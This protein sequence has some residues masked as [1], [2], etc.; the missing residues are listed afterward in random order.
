MAVESRTKLKN[1]NGHDRKPV[2]TKF[3]PKDLSDA[4]K[5]LE[6]KVAVKQ[7]MIK[8]YVNREMELDNNVRKICGI[9]KR[10]VFTFVE[11][12]FETR[13]RIQSER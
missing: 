10:A 9:V 5:K 4:D 11:N 7:Q 1:L 8:L 12:D 6:V 2:A 13:K 3:F